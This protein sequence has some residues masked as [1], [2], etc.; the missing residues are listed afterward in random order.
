M[1][2]ADS[3]LVHIVLRD[4]RGVAAGGAGGRNLGWEG[5][6]VAKGVKKMARSL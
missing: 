5:A 2:V 1:L 4:A 3:V 6:K